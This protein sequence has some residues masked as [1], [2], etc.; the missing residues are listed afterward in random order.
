[1]TRKSC[2]R[3]RLS[4]RPCTSES[5]LKQQ[6][7]P[8]CP[9]RWPAPNHYVDQTLKIKLIK[10]DTDMREWIRD[11]DEREIRVHVYIMCLYPPPRPASPENLAGPLPGLPIGSPGKGHD[12]GRT[13]VVSRPPTTRADHWGIPQPRS[14]AGSKRVSPLLLRGRGRHIPASTPVGPTGWTQ[15][16]SP[17]L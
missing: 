6:P 9:T 7:P 12:L 10:I 2:P 14:R 11:G 15:I 17:E 16:T 3:P 1:M 5:R 4:A 8:E 13:A